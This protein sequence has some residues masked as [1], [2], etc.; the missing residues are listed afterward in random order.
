M[1]G[2]RGFGTLGGVLVITPAAVGRPAYARMARDA[3]IRT[4]LPGRALPADIPDS[5]ALRRAILADALPTG[6][7]ATG[8]IAAWAHGAAQLPAVADVRTPQGRRP[9]V[10]H[11]PLPL[12][13]HAVGAVPV[14][15]GVR[16]EIAPLAVALVDAL[17]WG[18]RAAAVDAVRAAIDA[19]AVG[20]DDMRAWVES[21]WRS[22]S[23]GEIRETWP[24][25]SCGQ[26][27]L[28]PVTRRAS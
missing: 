13:I 17:R 6:A 26:G 27:R 23:A 21:A 22:R 9:R 4:V 28:A 20:L 12:V 16:P 14:A 3:V 19:G 8:L 25:V 5:P 2:A 7:Q 15:D 18:P 24:I 1:R 10:M 11:P